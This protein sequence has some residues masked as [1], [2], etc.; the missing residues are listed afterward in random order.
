MSQEKRSRLHCEWKSASSNDVRRF[1]EMTSRYNS[2]TKVDSVDATRE[3][4]C[5]FARKYIG[6]DKHSTTFVESALKFASAHNMP[7]LYVCVWEDGETILVG[8]GFSKWQWER[9]RQFLSIDIDA[10]LEDFMTHEAP[11]AAKALDL[12]H[13][14]NAGDRGH[15]VVDTEQKVS[16]SMFQ[17]GEGLSGRRA[18]AISRRRGPVGELGARDGVRADERRRA[19]PWR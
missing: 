2:C 3:D 10:Y 14:L 8:T 18:C 6:D 15:F 9:A 13:L 11:E 16:W 17:Y 1:F 19:M 7:L 12:R 5:T 4:L